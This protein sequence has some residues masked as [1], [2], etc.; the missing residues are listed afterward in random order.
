MLEGKSQ[1]EGMAAFSSLP[2]VLGDITDNPD[3][4]AFSVRR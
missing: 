2:L 3:S 1:K 4:D